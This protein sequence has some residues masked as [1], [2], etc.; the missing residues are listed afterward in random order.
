M[1]ILPPYSVLREHFPAI[2]LDEL[3]EL[4]GGRAR[5]DSITNGCAIRLSRAL[6]LAG[7][8]IPAKRK[9]LVAIRGEDGKRYAIRVREMRRYLNARYGPPTL[10]APGGEVAPSFLGIPGIIL[11]EVEIWSDATGHLDLWDGERC[12]YHG[13]WAEASQVFLWA[14]PAEPAT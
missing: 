14:T 2:A 6:N 5:A 7:Q 9:G 13:Y 4:I 12:E 10:T 8:P 11:F 1:L 3:K